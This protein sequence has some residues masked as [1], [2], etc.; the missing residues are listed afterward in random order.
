MENS[1][2]EKRKSNLARRSVRSSAYTMA[3]SVFQTGVN[4]V[5]SILLFRLLAPDDFGVYSFA[6]SL[7]VWT[8]TIPTFGFGA[9][10]VQRVEAS[11]GELPR[12]VHFTLTLLFASIWALV[13]F[14][15]SLVAIREAERRLVLWSLLISEYFVI[16]T[17]TARSVLIRKVEY[18]RM[19][20][21]NALGTV[22]ASVAAVV[23]AWKGFGVWSLAA[24]DWIVALVVVVGLYVVRPVWRPRLGWA[25]QTVRYFWDFGRRG[26]LAGPL[27]QSL[28]R[29]DDIWTGYV[30]GNTALGFYSRAYRLATYP[31]NIIGNPISSVAKGTYAE[32]K[33]SPKKLS[34]AFFRVN[35]FLIRS[36]FFLGGLLTL[37]APEFV[38]IVAGERWL[39]MV[40][41]FR[42]MLVFTLLDP[43][44][45][46]VADLFPAIGFPEKVVRTRFIQLGV[47]V[48]GLFAFGLPW[49]IEGVAIAVDLML[50]VG[51]FLFL[52]QA[53]A[54]VK[55]SVGALVLAPLLGLIFA[56]VIPWALFYFY[57]LVDSVWLAAILKSAL[58]SI[59]YFGFLLVVERK[60][61]AMM[62]EI[63][64]MLNP[65]K[66]AEAELTE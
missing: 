13:M 42:L 62:L 25:S 66:R 30:L 35:A 11:Q 27:R 61:L 51:I 28:D 14:T 19:A 15:F 16:L 54:Y 50:F 31:A 56:L 3:A 48:A 22:L 34:Q 4:F 53:R 59:F 12:R 36:G 9:A 23:L 1:P 10:L 65:G 63:M 39:P 43:L 45:M 57:F 2:W 60:Q 29:L 18:K 46:T 33:D 40:P 20:L 6:S 32:L 5:R 52:K 7:I 55:F 24:T 21:L 8:S 49:G 17:Q 26:F 44:K 64:K 37:I 47:L 58:F 38:T 41:V